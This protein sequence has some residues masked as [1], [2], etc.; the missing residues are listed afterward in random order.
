M[1]YIKSSHV[2][3]EILLQHMQA[4]MKPTEEIWLASWL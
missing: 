3:S 4:V 1:K 2:Y